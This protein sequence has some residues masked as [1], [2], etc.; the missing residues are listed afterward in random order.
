MNLAPTIFYW[1]RHKP[2][3]VIGIQICGAEFLSFGYITNLKWQDFCQRFD[4]A[5]LGPK[6]KFGR[7]RKNT[8]FN[9]L[10]FLLP[11]ISQK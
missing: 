3:E 6:K 5:K 9:M 10:L 4:V 2:R 11:R 8:G 1:P 7:C